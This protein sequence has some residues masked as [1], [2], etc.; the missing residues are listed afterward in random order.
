[1]VNS[2]TPVG[3]RPPAF[4][5][6][7]TSFPAGAALQIRLLPATGRP[8][9]P[10]HVGH[11]RARLVALVLGVLLLIV[12]LLPPSLAWLRKPRRDD[13]SPQQTG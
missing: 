9:A 10:G 12:A 6:S 11:P 7:R 1:V 3:T 13:Y 2:E 4:F 5:F 8:G